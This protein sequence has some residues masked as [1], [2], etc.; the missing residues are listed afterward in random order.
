VRF[1][2]RLRRQ[3]VWDP[4]TGLP[5][6]NAIVWNCARTRELATAHAAKLGGIDG[7]RA[8]TGLPIV[9]YFSAL[10]LVCHGGPRPQGGR[11]RAIRCEAGGR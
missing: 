10:K 4:A 1:V 7:L 6:Y 11:I 2:M 9:S 3:V 8:K 5:Y